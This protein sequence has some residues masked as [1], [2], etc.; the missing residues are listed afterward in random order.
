MDQLHLLQIFSAVGYSVKEFSDLFIH[1]LDVGGFGWG[2]RKVRAH[3]HRGIV[4]LSVDALMGRS[5]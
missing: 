2:C 4:A 3:A 1:K 5:L